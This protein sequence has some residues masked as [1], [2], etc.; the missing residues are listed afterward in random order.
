MSGK[1]SRSIAILLTSNDTSEFASHFPHDGVR[2]TALLQ[3][4]APDWTFETVPVKDNV[5]PE[6]IDAYDGYVITGSP[7]SVGG[8]DPWI[9]RLLDFIRAAEAR[10]IPQF[11]ACFG[12]QALALA[13]GGEVKKAKA[14][15][16][17]G[18]AVTRYERFAPW[19]Q[20]QK[21]EVTLY[22][23]HK[24]QVTRLPERAENLGG[25]DFCPIGSF[26]IGNHVFTTEYHPEMTAPFMT[27]LVE[28]MVDI[29]PPETLEKARITVRQPEEGRF[30]AQWIV[31]FLK[32]EA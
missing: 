5:F 1:T 10:K 24:E 14:G 15:W 6:S 23:A 18:T 13:L 32:G 12:H 30:F 9:A 31:N 7:A 20:P 29:L 28:E 27:G 25:D 2:F 11:G 19:M 26:R 17:L 4:F 22:S 8:D 3:P 16:G 21:R